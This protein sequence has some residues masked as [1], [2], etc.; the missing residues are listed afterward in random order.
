MVEVSN[1]FFT[2]VRVQPVILAHK[3]Q[4]LIGVDEWLVNLLFLEAVNNAAQWCHHN[5]DP[6]T[7]AYEVGDQCILWLIAGYEISPGEAAKSIGAYRKVQNVVER[8]VD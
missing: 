1:A 3:E 6:N 7:Q 4:P 8:L 5:S 2:G